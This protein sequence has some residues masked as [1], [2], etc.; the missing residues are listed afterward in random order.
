[1]NAFIEPPPRISLVLRLGIWFSEKIAGRR[2]LPARILAWY[3]EAA[4]GSS[5][6]ESLVA[7]HDGKLDERMLKLE[8]SDRVGCPITWPSIF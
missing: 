5:I 2:M 1:M 7:H 4:M 6:L 3:P 8:L